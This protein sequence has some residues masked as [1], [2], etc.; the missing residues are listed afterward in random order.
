MNLT[1]GQDLVEFSFVNLLKTRRNMLYICKE[2]V[3]TV[4]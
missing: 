4:L 3:R 1:T 2:S